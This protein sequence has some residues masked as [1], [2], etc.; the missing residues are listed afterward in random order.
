MMM[1]MVTVVRPETGIQ[2]SLLDYVGLHIRS[3]SSSSPSWYVTSTRG[4]ACS[5]HAIFSTHKWVRSRPS[6]HENAPAVHGRRPCAH[7][8]P[9]FRA[10]LV[11]T[12]VHHTLRSLAHSPQ[13][14]KLVNI[15]YLLTYILPHHSLFLGH[16]FIRWLFHPSFFIASI[17]IIFYLYFIYIFISIQLIKIIKH[18]LSTLS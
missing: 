6:K 8:S 2:L 5:Q 13:G 12:V 4:F 1:K 18:C 17:Y 10:L 15:Y 14:P 7:I 3:S 9:P 11:I 16:L